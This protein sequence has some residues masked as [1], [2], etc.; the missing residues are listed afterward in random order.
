MTIES[1]KWLMVVKYASRFTNSALREHLKYD[2]H[3]N[4][5]KAVQ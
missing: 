1:S 2:T 5:L 4:A 3:F